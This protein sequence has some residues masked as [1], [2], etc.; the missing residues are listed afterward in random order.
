MARIWQWEEM[1]LYVGCCGTYLGKTPAPNI[2]LRWQ[3]FKNHILKPAKNLVSNKNKELKT[4]KFMESRPFPGWVDNIQPYFFTEGIFKSWASTEDPHKKWQ[5]EKNSSPTR[6]ITSWK[7]R[8]YKG[9]ADCTGD[10]GKRKQTF[11][12]QKEITLCLG[13]L[14]KPRLVGKGTY[15]KNVVSFL[16]TGAWLGSHRGQGKTRELG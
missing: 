9:M 6:L 10:S 8:R 7:L 13:T 3:I 15:C 5:R 11:Y 4:Y 2:F 14:M 12:R 1:T 16:K